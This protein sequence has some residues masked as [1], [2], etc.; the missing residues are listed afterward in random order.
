M[1]DTL[2]WHV[3]ITSGDEEARV[4]TAGFD[5]MQNVVVTIQVAVEDKY[6][7]KLRKDKA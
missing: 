3:S 4:F 6:H 2:K 7:G 5:A 1:S